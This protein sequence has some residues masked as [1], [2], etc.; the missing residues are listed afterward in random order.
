MSYKAI[1]RKFR[2]TRFSDV[3][4]QEHITKILK[5]QIKNDN[6]AHAYLFSGTRGTGK[7]STA[8]IFAR[9]VNCTD[10]DSPCNACEICSKILD[11]SIMDIIEIDAAS[12]NSV[13]DIRELRENSK[14]PPSSCKY[15]V[16][17]IDE[18]HMLSKGA[19]NALL[20]VLEEPPKHLI[21]ILATTEVE[22]LPATI[23]SRC[24][25]Y[26]FKRVS[27]ENII[28]NMKNIS[29]EAGVN[30]DLKALELIARNSDG[31]MRDALSI[32]DQC[33]S[34][35]NEEI[36]YDYVVSVL[37][38]V[39]NDLMFS[40]IN[41][42]IDR[43]TEKVLN[44]LS[45]V[46]EEGIDI[47]QFIKDMITHFRNLMVVKTSQNVE[48]SINQTEEYISKLREQAN[49]IDLEKIIS[50]LNILT[51]TENKCKYSS[52]PRILLEVDLIKM[53]SLPKELD[54]VSLL[55]RIEKLEEQI[56]TG[57]IIPT[58]NL[59][60]RKEGKPREK[61]EENTRPREKSNETSLEGKTL[62]ENVGFETV[63]SR[64]QEILQTIKTKKIAL[65]AL[66]K[67]GKLV[68]F[69]NNILTI[70]FNDG[71]GFHRDALNKEENKESI[72]TI[73]K[74]VLNIKVEL[75]L[76]MKDKNVIDDEQEKREMIKD[77]IDV[78][79][80]DLVEIED[81]P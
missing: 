30:I 33:L 51:E 69:R 20:K 29:N 59:V 53:M 78:F 24:Q 45:E 22:K 15:K 2:P 62:D 35:S 47:R 14:Y 68:N 32:L 7:T 46:I 39:N 61:I 79:G 65:H 66:I 11:E 64:W 50:F 44:S 3:L 75:K 63:E 8:R 31:A 49:K 58:N 36:T 26:D 80:E 9:A 19:F 72:E 25:R 81:S 60:A 38:I 12:N 18:V 6:I 41:D 1:Y 34:F 17:I 43:S 74:S 28:K 56:K 71:F 52:Q 13:E 77:V 16:Y 76:I 70:S 23:I 4:G 55:T 37:G 10:E 48:N 67:E 73:I 54:L 27:V 42:I 40:I 5:N 57:N 21:F